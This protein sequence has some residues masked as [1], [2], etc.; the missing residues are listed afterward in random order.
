MPDF[1]YRV[2][3]GVLFIVDLCTGHVPL[4]KAMQVALHN[5]KRTGK[6]FDRVIYRDASRE[7]GEAIENE[8]GELSFRPIQSEKDRYMINQVAWR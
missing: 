5:I 6:Q 8:L 3:N 2:Y 7:W 1:D 4:T